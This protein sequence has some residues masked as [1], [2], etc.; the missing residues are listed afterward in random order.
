MGLLPP[1]PNPSENK[2][3]AFLG[4]EAFTNISPFSTL[5][6]NKPLASASVT[7]LSS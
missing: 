3:Q 5:V 1:P 2:S 4:L 7:W 6:S